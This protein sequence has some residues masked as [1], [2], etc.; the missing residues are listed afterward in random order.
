MNNSTKYLKLIIELQ[1]GNSYSKKGVS[2][3]SDKSH[4]FDT[5]FFIC[6]YIYKNLKRKKD[7]KIYYFIKDKKFKIKCSEY[8]CKIYNLSFKNSGK[9]NYLA[10]T[11]RFLE[12]ANIIHHSKS[13]TNYEY[14]IN[15]TEFKL[16]KW[17]NECMENAYILQYIVVYKTFESDKL[18]N[19]YKQYLDNQNALNI[20]KIENKIKDINPN[21]GTVKATTDSQ[22]GKQLVWYPLLVLGFANEG[23]YITRKLSIKNTIIDISNLSQNKQGTKTIHKNV[24][25]ANKYF[26]Y[27]SKDYV[28]HNL[29]KS[30]LLINNVVVKNIENINK[31]SNNFC[32]NEYGKIL[33]GIKNNFIIEIEELE[34]ES[35]NHE[36]MKLWKSNKIN[37][38]NIL[39]NLNLT[40][41]SSDNKAKDQDYP[42]INNKKKNFLEIARKKINI[43]NLG[44]YIAYE[45]EKNKLSNSENKKKLKWISKKDDTKGYDIESYD[46]ENNQVLHIEVK[47]HLSNNN[48]QSFI[49]TRNE[50]ESLQTD[51]AF[52]IYYVFSENNEF[53]L[54]I[55][56][57]EN[58]KNIEPIVVAFKYEFKIEYSN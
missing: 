3:L 8:I 49:L 34:K 17:I 56:N 21:I 52:V 31:T 58:L 36:L 44:E 18:L 6:K 53:F 25:K 7:G 26:N 48:R 10:E 20:E 32:V 40:N 37:K 30:G 33:D 38:V 47:T 24:A 23:F 39:T 54:S 43:G 46:L 16:F 9:D 27:F 14:E 45:Y 50:Y 15:E 22:W 28:I 41:N 11:I 42:N 35:N 12:Y 4:C 29:K 5:I 1:K 19:F 51:K 55:L 13:N 57:K 2:M